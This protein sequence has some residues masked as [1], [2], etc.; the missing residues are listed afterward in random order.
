MRQ[1]GLIPVLL[2]LA[3]P[4]AAQGWIEYASPRD[5]FSVNFPDQPAVQDITWRSEYEGMFPGRVYSSAAGPSRYA[6]TVIDYTDAE[7]I[8]AERMKSCHPDAHTGCSGS[9]TMGFGAWRIDVY[10][11]LEFAAW[12]FLQRDAKVT[13]YGFNFT[14]AVEGRQIHL[15]NP[16]QSRTFAQ[17][18]MHE[19]RLYILEATVPAGAPEP[20]LFQ[21]SLRFL[22]ADGR[23]VRY[24]T[25]YVNGF[26]KPPRTGGGGGGAQ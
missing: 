24:E 6:V 4:A 1:V 9:D 2:S 18:H 17:M 21:Q 11:V 3:V 19:N 12:K 13:F 20:G 10:G 5:F 15:T 7:K 26:P 25:L 8:H 23:G 16:D 22:D 14:D